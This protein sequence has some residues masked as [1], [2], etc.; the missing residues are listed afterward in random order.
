MKYILHWK[1]G[2]DEVIE[3]PSID[4]AM[5]NYGIGQEPLLALDYWETWYPEWQGNVEEAK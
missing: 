3:G 1:D 4:I 2:R 5:Y